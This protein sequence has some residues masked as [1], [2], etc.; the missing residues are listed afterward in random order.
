MVVSKIVHNVGGE[1]ITLLKYYS[2]FNVRQSLYALETLEYL[3]T[4]RERT[5]VRDLWISLLDQYAPKDVYNLEW[6]NEGI[7]I[8][9][10]HNWH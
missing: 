8:E 5:L 6:C 4:F 10:D 2:D 1:D 7:D 3:I 9:S